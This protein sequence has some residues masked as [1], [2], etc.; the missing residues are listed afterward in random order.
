MA[1][2]PNPAGTLRLLV[3]AE[4]PEEVR[5]T[6]DLLSAG[7]WE[8]PPA[9]ETAISL[10]AARGH[11]QGDAFDVLLLAGSASE[12]ILAYVRELRAG[13]IE[14]SVLLIGDRPGPEPARNARQAGFPHTRTEQDLAERT[15]YLDAL[16]EANP[17]AIVVLDQ[18]HKITL[19]N[20]AF[21]RLFLYSRSDVIGADL[22]NLIAP[23]EGAALS[24]MRE[25]TRRVIAGESIQTCAVRYRKDRTAVDVEIEGVPLIVGGRLMG[26]YAI[27]QDV[28]ERRQAEK[29]QAATYRIA[30]AALSIDD[31]EEFLRSVHA[32]ISNLMPARN[33]YIAL[34]DEEEKLLRFPYLVD[35]YDHA[36]SPKQ[37][38]RGLTEYVLRTGMPLLASP[39]VFERLRQE[40]EVDLIGPPSVDWLGVPLKA[41][42]RTIG[43]LVV[44]SYTEGVRF[45]PEHQDILTFVSAQIAMAIARKRAG[46]QIQHLAYHDVLTGLPNRRLLNDRLSVAIPQAVRKGHGLGILFLDL[47]RFKAVNDS[48]GHR[49]GDR[50]LQRV[51]ARIVQSVREADTAARVGGDEFIILLTE[52]EQPE[53]VA[54]VAEKLLEAL[55][56]PF[57]VDGRELFLSA[58]IGISLLPSDGRDG[59]TLIKNAD[60]AMYRAK[61]QGRDNYQMFARQMN[62]LAAQR[63]STENDL[64]RALEHGQLAVYY[65]PILEV[66]TKRIIGAE[67]LLRWRHPERGL[68]EPSEFIPIA[69]ET[70][71]I[72]P[73]GN[74]VL[75]QSCKLASR[76]RQTAHPS[77]LLA[78]NLSARQ[79]QQQGFVGQVADILQKTGQDP[80]LLEF[81]ITESVAMSDAESGLAM[82]AELKGLGLRLTI[83]DFGTGYSSL[84]LLKRLPVTTLKIDRSFVQDITSNTSDAAIAEAVIIIARGL[85]LRV[86]AEGVE[87]T[88]QARILQQYG[89]REM[90]GFLFSP[91]LPAEEFERLLL[92]RTRSLR[93]PA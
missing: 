44:Q 50:L 70:G 83:D 52:I 16:I 12:K 90:Q 61:E 29:I 59:E 88:E 58:S 6:C 23:P 13:G 42:D 84:S 63:F 18:A 3:V 73:I 86:V 91:P 10:D 17:L 33:L 31:F 49:I 76:W 34:Y 69:E 68:I 15:V 28:T 47:D 37:L 54:R 36:P 79:L 14:T 74:W 20:P 51:A 35:E 89:C 11:V 82:L 65:Q 62:V 21:E 2:I 9:F 53:H 38:G 64:R 48:L 30:E 92:Q 19:C 85:E 75:E 71:L 55:R 57:D 27:Y 25:I 32:I 46:Q 72:V 7:P 77:L 5:K 87:T 40:N 8:F 39:E 4:S 43:V 1:D 66:A 45:R 78:V 26:V 93:H 22:D 81:E 41:G 60:A 80:S 24:D 67:A 56:E